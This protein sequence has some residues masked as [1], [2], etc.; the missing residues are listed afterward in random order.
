MPGGEEEKQQVFRPIIPDVSGINMNK[1][2]KRQQSAEPDFIP[3]NK[4]GRDPT[5]HMMVL[6]GAMWVGGFLG[7]GAYGL[8]EGWRT[9][10][11]PSFKVR[12]N[13]VLNA[14]SKRGSKVGN[15]LGM[16][17]FIHTG[18]SWACHKMEVEQLT[19]STWVAPATAGFL[20]GGLYKST[21]APRTA[22]LAGVLGSGASC[23]YSVVGGVVYETI[24]GR[25]G[26]Y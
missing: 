4:D 16:V 11:T 13:S 6:T 9:A 23:A 18:F 10:Q 5:A 8:V 1:F 12:M 20:T 24:F 2:M 7:G 14:V 25:K 22:I 15:V 3:H 19:G 21:A 17:T 26:K